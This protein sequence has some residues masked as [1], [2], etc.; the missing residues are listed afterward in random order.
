MYIVLKT[1]ELIHHHYK[2][3][4]ENQRYIPLLYYVKDVNIIFEKKTR[5][6]NEG[7]VFFIMEMRLHIKLLLKLFPGISTS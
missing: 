1:Y 7:S 6:Q 4:S 5:R 2:R 3:L